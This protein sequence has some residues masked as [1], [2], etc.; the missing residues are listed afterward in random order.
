MDRKEF[1]WEDF[2]PEQKECIILK[3]D[4]WLE[5]QSV[6]VIEAAINRQKKRNE[7]R[8]SIIDNL[9]NSKNAEEYD[10]IINQLIQ[11]GAQNRHDEKILFDLEL[12]GFLQ[13]AYR[14][15]DH[16]KDFLKLCEYEKW[17]NKDV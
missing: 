6:W 3:Y 17:R 8:R 5:T 4:E 10:F 12:D 7:K 2:T 16:M 14:S 9:R 11:S 13:N 15:D 1:K